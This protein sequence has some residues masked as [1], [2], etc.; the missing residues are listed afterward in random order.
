[1]M[2]VVYVAGPY[3][4]ANNWQINLNI[5]EAEALNLEVWRAGAAGICPHAN[6]R[7]FQGALPDDHWL[8]GDFAIIKKCD[9]ILMTSTWERSEGACAEHKFAK[10][11]GIPVFYAKRHD[12]D[13]FDVVP[14]ELL[15]F[16]ATPMG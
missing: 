5:N 8:E 13:A 12:G 9:A 4:G 3:R 14:D 1:M 15:D 11:H 7:N 10:E 6:N 2:K 16:V